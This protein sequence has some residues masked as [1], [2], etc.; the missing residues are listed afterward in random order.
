[1]R[2]EKFDIIDDLL[3]DTL[4]QFGSNRYIQIIKGN[5]SLCEYDTI[6]ARI[7]NGDYPESFLDNFKDSKLDEIIEYLKEELN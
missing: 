5:D 7:E 3:S 1:M 4:I 2:K 6:L